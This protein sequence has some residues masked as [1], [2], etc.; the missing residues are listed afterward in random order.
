MIRLPCYDRDGQ[1]QSVGSLDDIPGILR[2]PQG[3]FLPDQD[4]M[5]MLTVTT[6]SFVPLVTGH[7]C[8]S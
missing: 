7:S 6:R 1:R 3:T 5:K 4:L 8:C 2:V